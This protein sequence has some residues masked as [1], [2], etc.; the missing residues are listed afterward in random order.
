M[1]RVRVSLARALENTKQMLSIIVAAFF[2]ILASADDTSD[3]LATLGL[4]DASSSSASVNVTTAL[5][6]TMSTDAATRD[7]SMSQ[8]LL[9]ISCAHAVVLCQPGFVCVPQLENGT[10]L[11][12][13]CVC[14]CARS[15]SRARARV[16]SRASW[17]AFCCPCAR[18]NAC[19]ERVHAAEFSPQCSSWC[20]QLVRTQR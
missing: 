16:G 10:F 19:F 12:V 4:N 14:V 18:G 13:S 2:A 15:Q 3:V 20:R 1:L 6:A 8:R 5:N 11:P 17:L 9:N 7:P